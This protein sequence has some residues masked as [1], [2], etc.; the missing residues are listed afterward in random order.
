[1][2]ILHII[3][4]MQTGGSETM[5][6]DIMNE[7]IKTESSV[8]LIVINDDYNEKLLQKLDKRIKI[9]LIERRKGMN[10]FLSI[11]KLNLYLFKLKPDVVHMHD[12][13][14]IAALIYKKFKKILT[15]H[16]V[17][18]DCKYFKRYN[19]LCAISQAVKDD[20]YKRSGLNAIII[21][22]GIHFNNIKTKK[23]YNTDKHYRIL[24]I[25][26][27]VH[28]K[29]G[30]DI[31]IEAFKIIVEKY[32][33]KNI[34]LNFIG[35]GSSYAYL[36][37]LVLKY[38]LNDRI[39]FLGLKNRDYIYEHLNEYNLLVQPSLFEG[40]GL[41]VVEGIAAKI[42]VL[43]SDNDGPI[44]IIKHGEYGFYFKKGNYIDCANAISSILL[45]D[46]KAI[47][48]LT[49]KGYDYAIQNFDITRTARE[50][51]NLYK[52]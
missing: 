28:L 17:D 35:E 49:D 13:N 43:V 15:I 12:T 44:E 37:E 7:Q 30:Q 3:F 31:L 24:Q 26:R 40:F 41:T 8:G 16:D 9:K 22:N 42:P 11:I 23:Q 32:P 45:L 48:D 47:T 21:Y 33:L 25:G 38:K 4:S 50:Y 51:L 27:L 46:E 52:K 1:M 6:I 29:K 5:L 14:V 18:I 19:T 10:T 34:T 36:N 39:N 2:K 20:V